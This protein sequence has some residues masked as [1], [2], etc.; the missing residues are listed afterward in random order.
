MHTLFLMSLNLSETAR[1]CFR[2]PRA[3]R[4]A[5]ATRDAA[6]GRSASCGGREAAAGKSRTTCFLGTQ[7]APRSCCFERKSKSES[8]AGRQCAG[9]GPGVSHSLSAPPPISAPR[10]A[11][12]QDDGKVGPAWG[13]LRLSAC[14]VTWRKRRVLVLHSHFSRGPSF[15]ACTVAAS[16]PEPGPTARDGGV[17]SFF[18]QGLNGP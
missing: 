10:T 2:T 9:A 17:G 16:H 14:L 1:L 13:K 18:A 8:N 6:A 4:A 11:Q 12:T 7:P 5:L 3:A 15:H